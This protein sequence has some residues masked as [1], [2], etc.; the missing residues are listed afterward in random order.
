MTSTVETYRDRVSR[1][2]QSVLHGEVPAD[3]TDLIDAGLIDSLALVTIIAEIESTF[4]IELPLDDL[5][6]DQFRSVQRIAEYLAHI[7]PPPA[8]G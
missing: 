7:A 4:R 6:V 3:D 2:I 1:L 5:D 8:P